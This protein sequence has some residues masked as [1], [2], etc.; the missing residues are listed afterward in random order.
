M[1]ATIEQKSEIAAAVKQFMGTRRVCYAAPGTE[2]YS[3]NFYGDTLVCRFTRSE[4][5]GIIECALEN[6][7]DI[8][9]EHSHYSVK[10]TV[11]MI[12][13]EM[14]FDRPEMI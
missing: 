1:N 11:K 10:Q 8:E 3:S 4:L 5:A 2:N 12:T 6:W 14:Q 13:D 7:T 9:N